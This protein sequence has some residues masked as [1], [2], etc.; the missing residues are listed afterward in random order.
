MIGP[1]IAI[2]QCANQVL[3][4]GVSKGP[5]MLSLAFGM[6]WC[7]NSHRVNKKGTFQLHWPNKDVLAG[8]NLTTS[9]WR[10]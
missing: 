7:V 1:M 4:A 2:N 5:M 8:N 3:L 9:K 6:V 10:F